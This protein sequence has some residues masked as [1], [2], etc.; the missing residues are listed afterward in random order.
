[1]PKTMLIALLLSA[2]VPAVWAQETPRR[3]APQEI[4]VGVYVLSLGKLDIST[5]AYTADFYLQL[6]ST[7]PIADNSFEFINGRA[8]AVEKLEDKRTEEGYEK[9]YRV[10]ANLST[11]ID[12]R[13]FPFDS[14]KMRLI[15][16]NKTDPIGSVVYR[17][18]EATCGLDAAIVFPGWRIMGKGW[19][20]SA[21]EHHYPV[22]DETY[23]Q[24]VYSVHIARIPFNSFLKTF[25]PVLFLILIV[26]SSFVLNPSQVPTRLA[27][28]SS[29]LVAS[30]MFHVSISNQIP[31]VGYLTFADKF[32]IATYLNLLI[33]FFLSLA[34]F[35]LQGREQ[36]EKA[37]RLNKINE[38]IVFGAM[39][40]VYVVLFL[41]FR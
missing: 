38:R 23:S 40:A 27:A 22:Y 28:I 5:G 4:F 13:K 30:V 3:G 14:Q 17:P 21:G 8:V 35:V 24:F 25:L 34:V 20:V 31:P 7:E 1:M 39:P 33:C 19:D 41:I 18:N 32:M 15:L 6:N 16:E 12:L 36:Q 2:A 26:M 9:F 10:L 37:M 29:T 11:P